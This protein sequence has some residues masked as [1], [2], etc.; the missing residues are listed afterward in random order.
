MLDISQ[1][2]YSNLES[3]RVDTTLST[4]AKAAEITG[5]S[6]AQLLDPQGPAEGGKSFL[7]SLASELRRE[8][9]RMTLE[10]VEPFQGEPRGPVPET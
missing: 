5:L 3:G 10:P 8:G 4:V 6:P 1:A 2:A 9:L 7:S